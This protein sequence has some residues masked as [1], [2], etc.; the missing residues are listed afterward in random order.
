MKKI[1]QIIVILSIMILIVG[2][3]KEEV[4]G[5]SFEAEELKEV[6]TNSGNDATLNNIVGTWL[7]E[8]EENIIGVYSI[9][10]N[11]KKVFMKFANLTSEYEILDIKDNKISMMLVRQIG[12]GLVEPKEYTEDEAIK[13]TFVLENNNQFRLEMGNEDDKESNSILGF[14]IVEISDPNY[15]DITSRFVGNWTDE[16]EYIRLSKSN[17]NLIMKLRDWQ[18]DLDWENDIEVKGNFNNTILGTI[19]ET[20]G[21]AEDLGMDVVLT[22]NEDG[23]L[24]LDDLILTKTNIEREVWEEEL[25]LS[26]KKLDIVYKNDIDSTEID[27][28]DF[29]G[30]KV[31]L[32]MWG[33]TWSLPSIEM[34]NNL[35]EIY[36]ELQEENIVVYSISNEGIQGRL[37]ENYINEN[38]IKVPNLNDIKGEFS[39]FLGTE[40]Y[41]SL[42]IYNEQGE[43]TETIVGSI[44]K[45]K[46]RNTILGE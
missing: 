25:K 26:K 28:Q 1:T 24:E 15:K 29:R 45:E 9:D 30:K 2:C 19:V 17:G 6:L 34:I 18:E 14:K 11:D 4:S 38:N 31:A 33:G 16:E 7:L 20:T 10:K 23:K 39:F 36:E 40:L 35:N 12:G 32:L 46:I 22:L 27:F 21:E 8:Y 37:A 44:D 43:R 3:Q 5:P 13:Y 41:P 42:Y